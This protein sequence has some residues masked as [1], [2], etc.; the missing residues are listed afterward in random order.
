LSDITLDLNS[1]GEVYDVAFDDSRNLYIIVGDF[2]SVQGQSRKNL[3]ILDGT[4][5]QCTNEAPITS[6]NGV[7][8]T[9]EFA[10]F[11]NQ[12]QYTRYLY[13]GGSF[14]S[15]NGVSSQRTYMARLKYTT[16]IM[17]ST[18][19]AV[20]S[21][22]VSNNFENWGN[23]G[24]YGVNDLL[25][26]SDTLIAVGDFIFYNDVPSYASQY[27]AAFKIEMNGNALSQ[28]QENLFPN[29]PWSASNSCYNLTMGH[30]SIRNIRNE[31]YITGYAKFDANG[32]PTGC[33]QY[34]GNERRF[35][36][37]E[38][39]ESSG[40]TIIFGYK[41]YAGG[42]GI[43]AYD[44]NGSVLNA[45]FGCSG[46]SIPIILTGAGYGFIE[47]YNDNV[48]Y[49][50]ES[51]I[52][53]FECT[54]TAPVSANHSFTPN[55][56]W[57]GSPDQDFW[58]PQKIKRIRNKL[59]VSGDQLTSIDG[60]SRT[61]LA[62]ICLEPENPSFF[63]NFD[64]LICEEESVIY[65]I[66]PVNYAEGYRW[67]YSGTG[68]QYRIANSGN[69]FQPLNTV[70]IPSLSGIEVKYP[71]G[72]T[73]G[74]LSVEAYSTCNTATDYLFSKP[75]TLNI[76]VVP[77]PDVNIVEEF[78]AFTCLVESFDLSV[79]SNTPDLLWVWQ[80][81]LNSAVLGT[82][83]TLLVDINSGPTEEDSSY[84]YVTGTE[85]INLCVNK[86]S[87]MIVYDNLA[88]AVDPSTIVQVP[89]VFDCATDSLYMTNTTPGTIVNW[90]LNSD[91][92]NLL[93]DFIIYDANDSL[94]VICYLT[95]DANGCTAQQAYNIDVNDE[96][97][98]GEIVGYTGS[99]PLDTLD[100]NDPNLV[101]ECVLSSGN[102]IVE[103]VID[104]V[105]AGNTLNL[106][107]S[108]T[109][110]MSAVN[111]QTYVYATT[112]LDNGCTSTA[113]AVIYFDFTTPFISS[114]SGPSSINCS[115][116]DLELIHD[117]SGGNVQEG[118]LDAS[119]VNTNSNSLFVN[120]IG[121]YVYE[122]ISL[123]NGCSV[124]DTIE[125]LLTTELLLELQEDILLCDGQIGSITV[126]PIN[127][128]ETTSYTWSNGLSGQ[129]IDVLGGTDTEVSV[130]AEN[131][132][133]CIGYD[134][135]TV[136]TASAI[137][138]VL[139]ASSGCTGG[140]VQVLSVSG[141][142]GSYSYS[143]DAF[144]W[145]Q[146]PVFSELPFGDQT[147]YIQDDLGCT[148]SFLATIDENTASFDMNFLAS[149][150]NAQGDTIAIV[151]VSNYTGFDSIG[152]VLPLGAIVHSI[153]DSMVVMSMNA[154]GWYD[155]TMLGYQDT[156]SYSFTNPV[157]FGD[158][159]PLFDEDYEQMGI[160]NVL[161]YPN[162]TL[163]SGA[164]PGFFTVDIELGIVQSYAVLVTNMSGQPVPG[165]SDNGVSQSVSIDFTFPLGTTPGPYVIHI[166]ADY[167]ARQENIILN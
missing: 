61:G 27:L 111:T 86:D 101:L 96:T 92:N 99:I 80:Y 163:M 5:L 55:F 46:E 6:M 68:A 40:D 58:T 98:T 18:S 23:G 81:D 157:Y 14:T 9:I 77:I 153:D 11:Q 141:G 135:I 51:S 142:T 89:G 74:V 48:Y 24:F 114:Y 109:V 29:H 64:T 102:G 50:G 21:W 115:A 129:T 127:N 76:Q 105:G 103:W 120:T 66:P 160:T 162:P 166:I 20:S 140:A 148:Y 91:P 67:T 49:A 73:S 47:S 156:C 7:I 30:W 13:I 97:L 130:I 44:I 165:M 113:N 35:H 62:L 93:T 133:G 71:A 19:Y 147:I 149:T 137:E 112:N 12:S 22:D 145:Q 126:T 90:A 63:N 34:C 123:D 155:V 119:G 146:D 159:A 134:T 75:L 138:A 28:F 52:D 132:S 151:N 17:N 53:V 36:D 106:S 124:E 3:A 38:V 2:T 152:W 83:N 45:P 70:I 100:C 84:Y 56:D 31:F 164:P 118:W 122:V 116:S 57:D 139:E 136:N 60:Q 121:S 154:A 79:Q 150:Y 107:E 42:S 161:V 143:M 72:A 125:I 25:L 88:E 104:G 131:S 39:H 69:A 33:I 15:I 59:F 95:Y 26:K 94:E 144:T 87:V 110:G 41:Q 167:D 78:M 16:G 8:R 1:G 32:N 85:L 54:S 37:L 158:Y 117:L 4:T 128:T 10:K 65:T 82:T 108:D 43:H